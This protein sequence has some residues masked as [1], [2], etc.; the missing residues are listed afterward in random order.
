MDY[1]KECMVVKRKHLVVARVVSGPVDFFN[2]DETVQTMAVVLV[3]GAA[4]VAGAAMVSVGMGGFSDRQ[5]YLRL[6]GE[7]LIKVDRTNFVTQ[8]MANFH[9]ASELMAVLESG[10]LCYRAMV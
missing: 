6:A 3:G 10:K 1:T 4:T 8:V 5:R 2:Y 7:R 9:D